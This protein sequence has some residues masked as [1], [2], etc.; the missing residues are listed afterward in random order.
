MTRNVE[1]Q[2]SGRRGVSW[3]AVALPAEHGS[4]G[5]LL[6][7][8]VLG[9]VLAPSLPGLLLALA[10][11]ASVLARQPLRLAWRDWRRGRRYART[12]V[13]ERF[14]FVY[15]SIV[16]V[17]LVTAVWLGGF[18]FLWP[19]LL[20]IPLAA[21]QLVYDALN[22]S[23]DL[24][25]EL[26][27]PVALAAT[28]TSIALAGGWSVTAAVV[29]WLILAIRDVASTLYV[30]ARLRLERGRHVN[31]VP[32]VAAHLLGLFIVIALVWLDLAPVLAAVAL[33]ILLARAAIGLSSYRRPVPVRVIG[34]SEIGY[35][36]LVVLLVAAGYILGF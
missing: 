25:P 2:R 7:P 24:L 26:T 31:V 20:A 11:I 16:V 17:G 6:E 4:W 15:A 14:A 23:R 32:A 28:V 36:A 30:R 19:L 33:F 8:I 13:A 10:V 27:G 3:R 18:A 35:G 29:L 22:R 21:V 5:F 12:L 9:L 1:R 34:F